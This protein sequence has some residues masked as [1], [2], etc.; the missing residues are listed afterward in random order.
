MKS[1]NIIID[2][3]P[4]SKLFSFKLL[5]LAN[6]YQLSCIYCG[7]DKDSKYKLLSMSSMKI[8]GKINTFK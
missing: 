6:K 1:A 4:L 5:E 7:M 8:E 2:L 3:A